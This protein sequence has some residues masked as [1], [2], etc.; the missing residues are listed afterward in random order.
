MKK[1]FI[2]ALSLAALLAVSAQARAFDNSSVVATI[3]ADTLLKDKVL[4]G[5]HGGYSVGYAFKDKPIDLS[6]YNAEDLYLVFDATIT[7]QNPGDANKFARLL[8][9][10]ELTSSGKNDVDELTFDHRQRWRAGTHTYEVPFILGTE[11][12]GKVDYS[13][14]NFFRIYCGGMNNYP[15]SKVTIN[16]YNI[17][18]VDHSKATYMPSFFSDGMLVQQ[19]KDIPIWGYAA[20]GKKITAKF[21]KG[22]TEI[23]TRTATVDKNGKWKVTFPAQKGS[24]D[25][26]KITV[27]DN[28][29]TNLT[30]NDI[31][32]G[33]L[34]VAGGQSNMGF[35]VNDLQKRDSVLTDAD[36]NGSA[37]FRF[38]Y[39]PTWPYSNGS[40]RPMPMQPRN[41]IAGGY[42]GHGNN[43]ADVSKVSAVGYLSMHELSKKLNVPVGFLYTPIGGTVIEGWIPRQELEANATM[44]SN[45]QTTGRY[46]AENGTSNSNQAVTGLYNQKVAPF[47][48]INVAGTIWYQ[49]ESNSNYPQFY[50]DELVALKHGWERTF[51][52]QTGTMPFVFCQLCRW[53][54]NFDNPQQIALMD[55]AMSDA[56]A[57]ES[58]FSM[59]P[60]YDTNMTW[61]G[62]ACIHPTYKLDTGHR[63]FLSVYNKVYNQGEESTAAIFKSAEAKDGKIVVTFDHVGNGLKTRDGSD[64]VRGFAIAGDNG[65][66]ANAT[67]KIISN[68]QVEV[69]N[70][71]ITNPTEVSYAFTSWNFDAN[72][73]NS[74]GIPASPFRSNRSSSNIYYNPQDWTTADKSQFWTFIENPDKTDNI[75]RQYSAY[76]PTYTATTGTASIDNSVKAVGLGSLKYSYPAGGGLVGPA[77]KDEVKFTYTDPD[78]KAKKDSVATETYLTLVPQ[79]EDYNALTVQVKNPDARKK[80]VNLQVTSMSG[81]I[82]TSKKSVDIPANADFTTISLPLND[83]V[84]AK[85]R[86]VKPL[87]NKI[88]AAKALALKVNDSKAGTLYFDNFLFAGAAKPQFTTNAV[89]ESKEDLETL[90]AGYDTVTVNMALDA[91]D[92][93]ALNAYVSSN[94]L[95]MLDLTDAT[96]ENN[97]LPA[98]AFQASSWISSQ[99]SQ[100]TAITLPK[101]ITTIGSGAFKRCGKLSKVVFPEG[102]K[103]ETIGDAT[104]S[105]SNGVFQDCASLKEITFPKSLK[106]I[107]YD[108]FRSSGIVTVNFED[109]SQLETIKTNAF[110]NASKLESITI[111]ASVTRIETTALSAVGS[112]NLQTVTFLPGSKIAFIGDQC[113]GNQKNLKS[114]T[115]TSDV[116]ARYGN[117]LFNNISDLKQI[118]LYVPQQY[119][120]NYQAAEQ[121]KD[122]NIVGYEPTAI[123]KVTTDNGSKKNDNYYD[124]Q[125]RRVS[126]PSHGIYIINGKKV[127]LK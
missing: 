12:G 21:L 61:V 120:A 68:N 108:T 111:P 112:G 34:W 16:L 102:C 63:F 10:I 37:D 14:I 5:S 22:D 19:N 106:T 31:L 101:S 66:F 55:E 52:F 83:F 18:I 84:D 91:E 71:G 50:T 24:F 2:S 60:L 58:T 103:L 85:G 27:T 90:V 76:F 26:Y 67:A 100:L 51:N 3:K 43:S 7:E 116:P 97:V 4:D 114:I 93:K 72:L 57:K 87:A 70:P 48:G 1:H 107:G 113:F 104:S 125:G 23:S 25:K 30:I 98:N 64:E 49:G 39:E 126:K 73:E 28:D 35:S 56:A 41:D 124:L 36:K 9:Q 123:G 38:F 75:H 15:D 88:K 69:S 78:T 32:V 11:N 40:S 82:F 44:K 77:V 95:K 65:V 92:V 117:R 127:V 33:E 47:A 119:L 118:T 13:N 80:S 62:N 42:W 110:L 122:L 94:A 46:V 121:W 109:G 89:V 96:F 115:M 20:A 53:A 29:K 105:T 17:R 86:T 6:K 74:V 54:T 45:I 59:I 81:E 99:T 8:G 79:L